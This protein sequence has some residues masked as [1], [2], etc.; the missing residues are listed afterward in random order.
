MSR[1]ERSGLQVDAA[2]AEFLEG[3]ALPGT[4]VK[5]SAFWDGLSS[6][7]HDLAPKNRA[8]LAKRTD[9]QRQISDWHKANPGQPEADAYRAFL[10]EIGYLVPEGP[11]FS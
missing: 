6:I 2:L 4:G 11:D 1:V 8:L 10:E 5:D 3:H 9:L 7:L